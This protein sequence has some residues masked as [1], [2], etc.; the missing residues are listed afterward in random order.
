MTSPPRRI[1]LADADA[2]YVAVARLVDPEGAGRAPLLIVGGSARDR[3]V[4]TSA[5]YEAR[6]YGV[7]SAMPMARATRL[8]PDA[9]VVPVPMAAC[10][11]KAREIKQALQ[12]FTPAVEQASSDEFYL[13]MTGTERLYKGE[14]LEDTAQRMRAAVQAATHLTV[15]IGGG[16]SRVIAKLAAGVAKPSTGGGV[17]IV[18]AGA[19]IDFM[20][21]FLL[22]DIHGI[23]PKFQERLDRVGLKSVEEALRKEIAWLTH[24]LGEREGHWLYDR[25]RGLDEG[26]VVANAAAKSISR[27]NTFSRDINDAA[28]LDDNLRGLVD[29]AVADMRDAD[30]A[31]RTITVRIRDADFTDRQAS[32]TVPDP[33]S[34]ERVV[35]KVA[36][37]LLKRLR[38]DR[39]YAARLL[40]VALSN[41]NDGAPAQLSLL[42]AEPGGKQ[43]TEK[44][45]KLTSA[46]DE[47]RGKFGRDAIARGRTQD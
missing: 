19:E 17:W 13:D 24:A 20:R 6:K 21:R 11:R 23:G 41:F 4:V 5:S 46:I 2:F 40:G 15:S 44:D 22:A 26:R 36:R 3:G 1:L 28:S 31:A 37:E 30:L 18:P 16:T 12:E 47:L 39:H 7:R 27:D 33:V 34:A 43:E 25:I 35:L 10:T 8:C 42:D 32:H 45:R 29:K 14:S 9:M 38:A